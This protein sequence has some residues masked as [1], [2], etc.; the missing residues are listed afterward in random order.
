MNRV[1]SRTE[2]TSRTV[3]RE[4]TER[5][6]LICEVDFDTIREDGAAPSSGEPHIAYVADASDDYRFMAPCRSYREAMA[7]AR[8]AADLHR[9]FTQGRGRKGWTVGVELA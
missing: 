3:T 6:E 2:K 1:I 8:I 5:H 7:V 9:A 4:S